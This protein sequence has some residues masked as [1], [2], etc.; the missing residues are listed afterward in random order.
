MGYCSLEGEGLVDQV[1]ECS[2]VAVVVQILPENLHGPHK[3]VLVLICTM[4]CH[5]KVLGLPELVFLWKWLF[6]EDIKDCSFDSVGVQSMGEIFLIDSG[7]TTDVHEDGVSLHLVEAVA[8][9]EKVV[10]AH[11]LGEGSEGVISF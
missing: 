9:V 11:H 5:E 6:L 8:P 2:S 1:V 4:W 3:P 10:G 7:A